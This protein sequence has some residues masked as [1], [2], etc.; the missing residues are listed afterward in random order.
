MRMQRSP[1]RSC[2]IA[3]ECLRRCKQNAEV[4]RDEIKDI[5][6]ATERIT[7]EGATN[8]DDDDDDD[9]GELRGDGE[10]GVIMWREFARLS[11]FAWLYKDKRYVRQIPLQLP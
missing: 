7:A 6:E 11:G 4:D 1:A 5:K 2:S 3:M 9:L 10:T 8:D